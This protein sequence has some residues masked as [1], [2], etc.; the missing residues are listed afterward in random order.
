MT[1][2]SEMDVALRSRQQARSRTFK[3]HAVVKEPC[4][5]VF[6]GYHGAD[7]CLDDIVSYCREPQATMWWCARSLV[8]QGD[9]LIAKTDPPLA[10]VFAMWIAERGK[11]MPRELAA[12]YLS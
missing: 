7:Q 1:T 11:R 4:S 5:Q 9:V 12:R 8:G 6:H 2:S 3:V 10:S